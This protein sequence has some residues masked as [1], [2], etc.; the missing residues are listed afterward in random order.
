[1]LYGFN[2]LA[3]MDDVLCGGNLRQYN[4]KIAEYVNRCPDAW[5]V[6]YQ[7]DVRTRSEHAP[8]VLDKCIEQHAKALR[9]GWDTSFDPARPWHPCRGGLVVQCH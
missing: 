4:A 2:T 8:R 5:G 6:V 9:R 1:M 3:I 7:A